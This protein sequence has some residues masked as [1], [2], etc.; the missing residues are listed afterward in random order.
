M[1][2]PAT[3]LS[4]LLVEDNPRHAELIRDEL[5]KEIPG[6]AVAL[7]GGVVEAR[8][9]MAGRAFD[10]VLLDF[11]LPD[12][13]GLEI[14]REMRAAGRT[15]PIV[16]VTTQASAATAVEAMK[17]G[18]ADYVVKEEGYLAIVP[19][20]V[21]DV[22]EHTRLRREREELERRLERAESA[23]ALHK[24]AAGIAH[25]LNNP[26]TTVRTFLELLPSRW[27]S[28]EEFRGD[29][30][31][32]VL[33]ETERIRDLVGRMMRT[34]VLSGPDAE[35]PWHPGDLVREIEQWFAPGLAERSL[36]MECRVDEGLPAM[37]RGREAVRQALVVLV[38]N[39]IAFSPRGEA[40]ALRARSLR[41]ATTPAVVIEV[42]DRGP[43]V[44]DAERSR[45]C[46]PFF[47]TRA[48]GVG[49]GLFVA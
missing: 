31:R 6:A 25:N 34:A 5:E 14:L 27:N 11:R 29:Y 24:L 32:L 20:V 36:R 19:F 30:Y 4:I 7:A 9:A 22:L 12:G 35:E 21:R 23:A 48:G 45:I 39:A 38:D 10:V 43:C 37:R 3:P 28:D 40:I 1:S 2:A 49:I 46:D 8:E 42:A 33:G 13:D 18:A 44:S 41:G 26:L 15:E 17:L 16:F 47:S